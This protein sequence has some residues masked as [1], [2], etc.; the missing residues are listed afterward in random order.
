MKW[1]FPPF[2]L[3]RLS[4]SKSSLQ[5]WMPLKF[6]LSTLWTKI[7]D[8]ATHLNCMLKIYPFPILKWYF[9]LMAFNIQLLGRY[10]IYH[11]ILLSSHLNLLSVYTFKFLVTVCKVAFL[12][13][14]KLFLWILLHFVH[15]IY[16]S[17]KLEP[18][19]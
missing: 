10:F 12:G 3:R 7:V 14:Y 16:K 11:D 5:K 17:I 6:L 2:Y 8:Y 4:Q 15:F 1:Y 18:L 19:Q 9:S 13:N